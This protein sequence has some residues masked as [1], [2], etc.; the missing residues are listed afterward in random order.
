MS[1]GT[2]KEGS[3]G[4]LLLAAAAGL[5]MYAVPLLVCIGSYG[6]TTVEV[7]VEEEVVCMADM[8]CSV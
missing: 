7:A 4:L 6:V 3:I 8:D 1:D 5:G 2:Q